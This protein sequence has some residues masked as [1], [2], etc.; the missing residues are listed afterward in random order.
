MLD[1]MGVLQ[2]HD[3]VSG[4]E[5]QLV[6]DD[7]NWRLSKA[8]EANSFQ[9]AKVIDE[10]IQQDTGYSSKSIQWQQCLKTNGTY[11]DCP[12][13]KHQDDPSLVMA[14]VV[15]NPSSHDVSQIKI[16]VPKKEYSAKIFDKAKGEFV[17]VES[18]TV[19]MNDPTSKDQEDQ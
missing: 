14:V 19:C 9:Y 16:A 1:V 3:A 10:L 17:A 13:G 12:I 2:H 4:T 8:V 11:L 5:R 15:H 7:Y 18:P 6:A